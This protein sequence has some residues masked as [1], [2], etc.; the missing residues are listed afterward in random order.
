MCKKWPARLISLV[1]TL[2]IIGHF[3]DVNTKFQDIFI[4]FLNVIDISFTF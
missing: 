3:V 1:S 2:V 4:E